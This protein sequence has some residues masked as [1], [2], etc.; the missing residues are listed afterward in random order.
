M[1][2]EDSC[3]GRR[4]TRT[5]AGVE[6]E[7][8]PARGKNLVRPRERRD[9]RACPKDSTRSDHRGTGTAAGERAD[10]CVPAAELGHCRAFSARGAAGREQG[11]LERISKAA[12]YSHRKDVR[13]V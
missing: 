5:C 2:D 13:H 6:T 10:R 12:W 9:R 8:E 3:A 1:A 4:W 7:P 11:F